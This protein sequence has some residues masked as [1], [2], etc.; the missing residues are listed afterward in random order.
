MSDKPQPPV[1][2]PAEP[3][4]VRE[5]RFHSSNL[6]GISLGPPF[7][8]NGTTHCLQTS[9]DEREGVRI[10]FEPWLRRFRAT[11]YRG[12]KPAEEVFIPE[13]WASYVEER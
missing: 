5:L 13:S 9:K 8:I 11:Y 7:T 4:R 12:G 2:R 10:Q 1:Q 6:N 3:I